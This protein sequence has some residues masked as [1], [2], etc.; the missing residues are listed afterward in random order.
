MANSVFGLLEKVIT[1]QCQISERTI[2]ANRLCRDPTGATHPRDLFPSTDCRWSTNL[3]RAGNGC[4]NQLGR[5]AS[6][7]IRHS[8]QIPSDAKRSGDGDFTNSIPLSVSATVQGASALNSVVR[9]TFR[10]AATSSRRWPSSISFRAWSICCRDG[11]GS[12]P[13]LPFGG[14]EVDSLKT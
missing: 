4:H 7:E 3:W 10:S 1:T 8:G 11:F 14:M 9:S 6:T 2:W 13:G 12:G 5:D